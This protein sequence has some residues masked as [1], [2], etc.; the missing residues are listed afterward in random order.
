[1]ISAKKL[2]FEKLLYWKS[3]N[4]NTENNLLKVNAWSEKKTSLN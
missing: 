4:L 3:N 1:M 2:N